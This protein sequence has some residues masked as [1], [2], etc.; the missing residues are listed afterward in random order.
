MGMVRQVDLTSHSQ[1]QALRYLLT[2]I[3][4]F[5]CERHQH[6]FLC[7]PIPGIYPCRCRKGSLIPSYDT[8]YSDEGML[9]QQCSREQHQ[10]LS[11][12]PRSHCVSPELRQRQQ[13]FP[14]PLRLVFFPALCSM[15]TVV[16]ATHDPTMGCRGGGLSTAP[17]IRATR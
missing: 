15:P 16:D 1:R 6:I 7:S 13:L 2:C 5:S 17:P 4:Q 8:S 11:C 14:A 10:Q 9:Q 12:A 3:L